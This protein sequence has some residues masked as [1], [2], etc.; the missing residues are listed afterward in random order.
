M[1]PL[2]ALAVVLCGSS[3][4]L[5]S[6]A[7]R[8]TKQPARFPR[9]TL[10]RCAAAAV[11]ALA[12]VRLS[13]YAL[14]LRTN[15]DLLGLEG[16]AASHRMQPGTTSP[17]TA[18]ALA[19]LAIS[20]LLSDG[21]QIRWL[22]QATA[23]TALLVGWLGFSRYVY[24]GVPLFPWARMALYTSFIVM[25]LA[26][27]M[28]SLRADTGL[29]RLLRGV[30]AGGT[31]ARRLLPAGLIIPLAS[32][33]L[34]LSGARSG[35]LGTEQAFSLFA[36]CSVIVFSLLVWVNG[37][38]LESMDHE[39]RREQEARRHSEERARL[40]I[41]TALD[42]VITI[43]S[44]GAVTGWSQQAQV[45]FGWDA[46]EVLGRTLSQTVIPAPQRKAHEVGLKRYLATGEARVL[47]RRIE[48]NAQRRDGSEFPIEI[49]I[50]PIRSGAQIAFSAFVRDIT[51]RKRSHERLQTQIQRL[52]LLDQTTRA[53]GEHQDLRSIFQIVV[54][55][56]E[57]HLPVDLCCVCTF[58]RARQGFEV[59]CVGAKGNGLL[60]Q[61][62]LSERGRIAIDEDG[63]LRCARGQLIHEPDTPQSGHAFPVRLARSGLRSLVMCPLTLD[64]ELF[65]IVLAARH[66]A[67][68]FT[69]PDC[70][71]L[72]QLSGH[73]A[74]AV[75][76]TQLHSALQQAYDDLRQTQQVV[77]Q[78]ERLRAL[79][80]MASGIAHDIN[81]ALSPASLY[82]QSLLERNRSLDTQA[83][84]YLEIIRRAID[85]V[86]RTVGRMREFYRPRDLELTLTS[87]D[88]G[89]L[90]RQVADLTRARWHDM[91]QERGAVIR[92]EMDVEPGL[93]PVLGA[94]NE[95]RDALTNLVLNAVDAMPD[96]GT[97]ALRCRSLGPVHGSQAR[98]QSPSYLCVEICDT[99]VG[100]SEAVR[101]RCLEPFFT[102]KGERGTGLGLAMVY[103][104]AQRHSAELEIDSEPGRGTTI[105]LT[106]AATAVVTGHPEEAPQGAPPR[107][108]LLVDDDPLLLDS[109]RA[110]LESDGHR[111][112][113]AD[114]GQS[115]IDQFFAARSTHEPFDLVITDLGMPNV[116]G[117]TVAAAVKSATPPT[118]VILLTGWG[119]RL[120]A[121]QEVPQ[122][123]DR[124]LG[125]PPRLAELRTTL[126]ELTAQPV[127]D[128]SRTTA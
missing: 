100:M 109:L 127:P 19:A 90:L 122:N 106:F 42:A 114:G 51:E 123:V 48:L 56:L 70:E 72:R 21:R 24:G 1:A 83:R 4:L 27:G 43:N 124:M 49:A 65:G 9:R 54:G 101:N 84:E 121:E 33:A 20:L 80:Q 67:H 113:V 46:A 45:M 37:V 26:I 69:S 93:P 3:L 5:A 35:L 119:H 36:L 31:S 2:T 89:A 39:R 60:A 38:R 25:V 96:G 30:G 86:A 10:A 125:K 16:L 63:L 13:A 99:G 87:L 66:E 14:Q 105:R 74:L 98:R 11:L 7:A 15:L 110:I 22:F 68:S 112:S 34:A 23:L 12:L 29:M 55:N 82:A 53:V 91:P 79:G 40:I 8:G 18:A 117:R 81:N 73:L 76:Q 50:T 85:D 104:M 58:D 71:F 52:S 107:R 41:D 6:S 116:D 111:I 44:E 126:A 108:I 92:L 32:G 94:Q 103:G 64:G 95:I 61:L 118:P 17:A 28:L 128:D 97:L 120:R 78:Q 75:R 57:R 59:A 115:G 47:H 102:T 88:L 62:G 77:F